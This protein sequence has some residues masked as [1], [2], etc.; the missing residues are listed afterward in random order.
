MVILE[1]R[2]LPSGGFPSLICSFSAYH[3]IGIKPAERREPGELPVGGVQGPDLEHIA[4][5]R[6]LLAGTQTYGLA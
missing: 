3:L 4:S 2:L 5:V 1:P 6:V